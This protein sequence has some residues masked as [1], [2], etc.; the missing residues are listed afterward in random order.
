M[1]DPSLLRFLAV[2]L[3]ITMISTASSIATT[4]GPSAIVS[5]ATAASGGAMSTITTPLVSGLDPSTFAGGVHTVTPTLQF[6]LIPAVS[7]TPRDFMRLLNVMVKTG[8]ERGVDRALRQ[9]PPAVPGSRLAMA[10]VLASRLP[11]TSG[12]LSGM[13]PSIL[14]FAYTDLSAGAPMWSRK[15]CT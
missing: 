7:A 9:L 5:M 11:P 1:R 15:G 8:I 4:A 6:S 14:T 2:L 10:H 13:S 3:S 12:S